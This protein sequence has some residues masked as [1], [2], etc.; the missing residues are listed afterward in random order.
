M[1]RFPP[2]VAGFGVVSG[3]VGLAGA[4]AP[5][6]ATQP[7]PLTPQSVVSA[8]AKAR[9]NRE[10]A[11]RAQRARE[12]AAEAA[13]AS[14]G[15]PAVGAGSASGTVGAAGVA[16]GTVGA[17]SKFAPPAGVGPAPSVGPCAGMAAPTAPRR[18]PSQEERREQQRLR[19]RAEFESAGRGRRV[20]R[21]S[22]AP[23]RSPSPERPSPRHRPV[24]ERSVS[25]GRFPRAEVPRFVGPRQLEELPVG[26]RARYVQ[27]ANLQ[28]QRVRDEAVRETRSTA[29][30]SVGA[31]GKGSK[32]DFRKGT[33]SQPATT[34]RGAL[35]SGT[36]GSAAGAR[37]REAFPASG[38]VGDAG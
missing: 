25:S 14:R 7:A 16:S 20:W 29:C 30:G 21:A 23:E 13:R 18:R 28:A 12:A 32:R 17:A 10:S 38:T 19:A 33:P 34:S 26:R 5:P 35:G 11:E 24:R 27:G 37:T 4:P 31:A 6:V 9:A 1:G 15:P 8:E 2:P 22:P 3:T 36:V